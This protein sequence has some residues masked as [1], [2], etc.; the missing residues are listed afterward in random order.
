MFLSF[1]RGA[2]YDPYPIRPEEEVLCNKTKT[3]RLIQNEDFYMLK[4]HQLIHENN[5]QNR[6]KR[7]VLPLEFHE[8]VER[9]LH[10]N[11]FNFAS[12]DVNL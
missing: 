10:E 11:Q 8:C 1:V 3:K 4:D 12:P 2:R 9:R 7:A 6:S 5:F